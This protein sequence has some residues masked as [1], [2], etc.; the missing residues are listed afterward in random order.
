MYNRIPFILPF[1]T[2]CLPQCYCV[3]LASAYEMDIDELIPRMH[4]EWKQ[5]FENIHTHTPTV[6]RTRTIVHFT[7]TYSSIKIEMNRKISSRMCFTKCLR[8]TLFF[9]LLNILIQYST[10]WEATLSANI[11]W[12]CWAH[13]ISQSLC[14]QCGA[15]VKHFQK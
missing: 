7:L 13:T 14:I 8:F 9:S 10:P 15:K 3:V 12:C 5:L 4:F 11:W 2:A 1:K 6:T